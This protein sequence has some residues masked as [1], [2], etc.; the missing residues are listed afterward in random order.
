MN[1]SDLVP[2]KSNRDSH[3]AVRR[4]NSPTT[5]YNDFNRFFD[6]FFD[7]NMI[8]PWS[9]QFEGLNGFN[10]SVNVTERDK[11]FEVTAELPGMTEKDIDIT[12]SRDSLTIKGEKKQETEDK[13]DN[14]YRMERSYG[15]FSR[16]IPLPTDVVNNDKVEA[17]FKNGV[18][19]ITLPKVEEAQQVSR[20]I[21][22][23]AG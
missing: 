7:N 3:V 9:E 8:T 19:T 12:L 14:Y 16:L 17:S 18:L 22:V 4:E 20:R 23:N 1:I 5:F 6:E 15:K 10:P 21:T 2:W 13:G 11:E